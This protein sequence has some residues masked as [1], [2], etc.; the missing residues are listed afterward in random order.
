[1]V[2]GIEKTLLNVRHM[3]TL[4]RNIISLGELVNERYIFE[5]HGTKLKVVRG[6]MISYK[7]ELRN[8]IYLLE[9]DISCPH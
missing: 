3:P 5:G 2:D 8:C 7:G 6:P 1:M 9:R 4:K